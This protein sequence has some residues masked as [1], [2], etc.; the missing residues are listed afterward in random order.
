[1]LLDRT[2]QGIKFFIEKSGLPEWSTDKEILSRLFLAV[3]NLLV[4]DERL[5]EEISNLKRNI[6]PRRRRSSPA[7]DG[8]VVA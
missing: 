6:K 4:V 8:K 1:M 3:G 2:E 7:K 5:A